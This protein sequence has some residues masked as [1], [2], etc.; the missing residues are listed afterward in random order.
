MK[1]NGK[2]KLDNENKKALR[3]SKNKG[4]R[5]KI[6]AEPTKREKQILNGEIPED[7]VSIKNTPFAIINRI[8]K[9]AKMAKF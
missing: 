1:I 9:R 4:K 5:V 8:S 2:L 3:K 7:Y 6:I